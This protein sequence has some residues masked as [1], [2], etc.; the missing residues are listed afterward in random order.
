MR[1]WYDIYKERMNEHYASVIRAK[2]NFLID[3]ICNAH[4]TKVVEL[5]CGA[6]NITRAVR[7]RVPGRDFTMIDSCHQML[8]LAIENNRKS[9]CTFVCADILD[10]SIFDHMD[11]KST[12]V[13]SHGVLEHFSNEDILK[14]ID[15]SDLLAD[16]QFHYVPSDKYDKPSRGDERLMSIEW[17]DCTL[18]GC[19]RGHKYSI[20]EFNHGKDL[21]LKIWRP[22]EHL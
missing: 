3:A 2:Y 18:R 20:T 7:E 10:E 14:I 22:Y 4:A 11:A 21:L 9:K 19:L 17:W 13:H 1:D 5:G 15:N 8:G 16:Q 6:G 12:I